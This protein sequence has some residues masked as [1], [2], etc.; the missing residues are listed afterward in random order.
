[1]AATETLLAIT[2][3]EQ[4]FA[5]RAR[6]T[7]EKALAEYSSQTNNPVVAWQ[8]ARACYDWAN[9]ATNKSQNT[10]ISQQ[11][12]DA[13]QRS[14]LITNSAAA[15]Y[16][17]GLNLG[18]LAQSETFHG[19]R[20][21]REMEREWQAAAA[22]DEH[23]DFAGPDRSLGLLY[24]DAPGWPLSLG[25][26]HNALEFLQN[27]AMLAPDDP[28]NILNLGETYLKWGDTANA[29]RELKILDAIWPKAQKNLAGE[30]WEPDW[31]DWL[32][33]RDALRQKL[34]Q[35]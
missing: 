33:R 6:A 1:M 15:H 14:L 32:K 18:Q 5:Q 25:S 7:Y 21:V 9:W 20:L 23:F 22:L 16:Y 10:M 35:N 31:H 27:A 19:L 11:G 13:C 28:E 2:G 29:K 26:R 24:R 30:A 34:D 4:I 17:M 3:Q 12:I 8:F